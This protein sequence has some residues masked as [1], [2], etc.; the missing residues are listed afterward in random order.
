MDDTPYNLA[1]L[2]DTV[3]GPRPVAT[4]KTHHSVHDT[5][6]KVNRCRDSVGDE[7]PRPNDDRDSSLHGSPQCLN[8][9]DQGSRKNLHNRHNVRKDL[10]KHLRNNPDPAE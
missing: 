2:A 1:D 3:P 4:E 8:H 7:S 10:R 5:A 6:N 9:R